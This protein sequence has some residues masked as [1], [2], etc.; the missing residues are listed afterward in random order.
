MTV[1]FEADLWM[2]V[3]PAPDV[4]GEWIAHCLNLDIIS[5]GTSAIDALKMLMEAVTIT[6]LD[7]M[8]KGRDPGKRRSAPDDAWAEWND[9]LKQGHRV[10]TSS[11]ENS[12]GRIVLQAHLA[13]KKSTTISPRRVPMKKPIEAWMIDGSSRLSRSKNAKCPRD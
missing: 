7:D 10:P 5:Q 8:A 2:L 9:I 11:L 3:K 13:V 1:N 6:V 4:R 12:V